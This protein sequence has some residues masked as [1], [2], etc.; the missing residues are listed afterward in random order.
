[1][2]ISPIR[3]HVSGHENFKNILP[4]VLVSRRYPTPKHG[5][6]I[7]HSP[8]GL[9]NITTYLKHDL[10]EKQ[11][12]RRKDFEDRFDNCREIA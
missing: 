5:K 7:Y 12:L 3:I 4:F 2:L 9:V 1:V 11:R 8:G 6:Q 10:Q